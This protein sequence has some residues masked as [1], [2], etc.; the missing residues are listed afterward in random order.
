M[1]RVT[2][3]LNLVLRERDVQGL[4]ATTRFAAK[5]RDEASSVLTIGPDDD[6]D[7]DFDG[8]DDAHARLRAL[9][10]NRVTIG[11]DRLEGL[12]IHY[13][14]PIRLKSGSY[15]HADGAVLA[16]KDP[17][18]TRQERIKA[19]RVAEYIDMF[20]NGDD[21]DDPQVTDIVPG[22]GH[23]HLNG[24]HRMVAARLLGQDINVQIWR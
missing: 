23:W 13:T 12:D 5:T 20:A 19:A 6:F 14:E 22:G 7:P 1:H 8:R 10:G 16:A 3:H 18:F 2:T 11:T 15:A 24:L 9:A 17:V 21:V 4:P